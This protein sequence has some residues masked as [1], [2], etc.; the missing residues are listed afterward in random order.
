MNV[1][2]F[3]R[4]VASTALGWLRPRILSHAHTKLDLLQVQSNNQNG[5]AKS[6]IVQNERL[7]NLQENKRVSL[8]LINKISSY[9]AKWTLIQS[10]CRIHSLI[11]LE[12]INLW[13]RFFAQR[14]LSRKQSIKDY[15]PCLG[16][17][18]Y[19][20]AC[21]FVRHAQSDSWILGSAKPLEEIS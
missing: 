12:G 17:T 13:R 8:G 15:Y 14:D 2:L 6:Q 20:Q 16:G 4:L 19:T 5:T 9:R 3:V 11:S 18:I 10:D 1:F 7:I 21:P